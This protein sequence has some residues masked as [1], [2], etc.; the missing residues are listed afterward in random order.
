MQG[1][2]EESLSD[3][4]F[5]GELRRYTPHLTLGRVGRNSGPATALSGPLERLAEFDGGE[6]L[7]EGVHGFR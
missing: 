7:V 6:M 1:A 5:R 4:G 3:L 2:I